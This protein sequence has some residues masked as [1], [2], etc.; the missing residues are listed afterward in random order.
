VGVPLWVRDRGSA[1]S[2]LLAFCVLA[3]GGVVVVARF[4]SLLS[5]V[6]SSFYYISPSLLRDG[7][8]LSD[9]DLLKTAEPLIIIFMYGN[10]G[11][12]ADCL[13]IRAGLVA[14]SPITAASF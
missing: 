12:L 10:A 1:T 4:L 7:M 3:W 9:P 13:M 14:S 2:S 11:W 8:K 6:W 5:C